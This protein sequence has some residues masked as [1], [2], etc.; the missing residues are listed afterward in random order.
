MIQMA[1]VLFLSSLA[2]DH[3]LWTAAMSSITSAEY[4]VQHYSLH[5]SQTLLS[6]FSILRSIS[7]ASISTTLEDRLIHSNPASAIPVPWFLSISVEL[8]T[9]SCHC[10]G[11]AKLSSSPAWRVSFL[12]SF[13]GCFDPY[14]AMGIWVDHGYTCTHPNSYSYTL[15]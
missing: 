12:A 8:L 14:Q 7:I 4:G 13:F 11:N 10:S 5:S 9:P 15:S 1:F 2:W 3:P 6:H